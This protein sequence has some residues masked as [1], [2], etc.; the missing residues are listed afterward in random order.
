MSPA[1]KY[2][3]ARLGI[4]LAVF[5]LLLPVSGLGI[6]LK[7]MIA[8]LFSAAVSWFVLRGLRD[9]VSQQVERTVDRRREERERLRAALAGDDGPDTG[10]GSTAKPSDAGS[11]SNSSDA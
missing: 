8:I 3:L 6:P 2:T 11:E 1:V 10:T 4:F 7:L 5:A 9:R